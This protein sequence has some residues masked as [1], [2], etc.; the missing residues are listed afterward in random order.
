MNKFLETLFDPGQFSCFTESPHGYRVSSGPRADDLFFCINALHPYKDLNPVKEWHSE[1]LPRRADANVVS[2][3]NFLIELDTVPLE[4][5]IA[6]VRDEVPVSSV[7]Y[8]GGKSHHFILSLIEPLANAD[9]YRLMARRLLS[10][11][12][13]ADPT[14][15]NPS[16][17]SRLPDRLRP[18]TDKRQELV[19]LG[20][21]IARPS[22]EALLPEV[23]LYKPQ[24]PRTAQ[25]VKAFVTPLLIS[26]CV[27]PD[28]FMS[29]HSIRGRN[30]FCYWLGCRFAELN[31]GMESRHKY[32]EMAY[33]N[34]SDVKDFSF[35]EAMSAARVRAQ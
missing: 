10:L 26:A 3:R 6:Y 29:E 14:C 12:P 30:Q 33:N 23:E 25:D 17:L 4:K 9:E 16:R 13:E 15:K 28:A 35:E 19:H 24:A 2:Y 7:V 20:P 32:L 1:N 31:L 27:E 5:Q 22:L 18:E 8:S 21:R 11:F 34:L